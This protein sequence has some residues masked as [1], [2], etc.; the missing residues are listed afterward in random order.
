MR[1]A[2]PYRNFARGLQLPDE[3][4]DGDEEVG[5]ERVPMLLVPQPRRTKVLADDVDM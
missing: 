5:C 4:V 1:H 2:A 3:L